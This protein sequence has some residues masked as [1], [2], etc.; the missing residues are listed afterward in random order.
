MPGFSSLLA[1]LVAIACMVASRDAHTDEPDRPNVLFISLDDLNDWIGCLEG[2]PQAKTPNIDRLAASGVLFENAH[3]PAPAC[4]PSRTAILTGISPHRS[5]LYRNGQRMRDV[6]PD[7]E[8][9]PKHFAKNGYWSAGSG[10]ILHYF[11]DA[12][13]WD[14]Y[15]PR[16]ESE[17]PFPPHMPWGK[18]PKSLPRGG[19]W[20]YV[21]TDWHAYDVSDDE[22]GSTE[23][24]DRMGK[25]TG[26]IV[27]AVGCVST[28][29]TARLENQE[30][31]SKNP[32]RVAQV[33]HGIGVRVAS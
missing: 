21:E 8:L 6:L 26:A 24:I 33:Y 1:L 3:C 11:I 15:Y 25:V 16:K 18:R 2:H 5:G 19:P 28:G 4:N 22:F 29:K 12:R 20:Q 17:N 23:N 9:L 30:Q 27:V 14:E 7:A 31:A 32:H 10:K 13:S